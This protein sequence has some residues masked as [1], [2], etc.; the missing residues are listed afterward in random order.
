MVVAVFDVFC[1]MKGTLKTFR[2]EL[3]SAGGK[4]RSLNPM[5]LRVAS[6]KGALGFWGRK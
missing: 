6:R 2:K 1:G 3:E 4:W 5:A